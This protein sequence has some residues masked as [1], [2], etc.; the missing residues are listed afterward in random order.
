MADFCRWV[1]AAAPALGWKD[2]YFTALYTTHREQARRDMVSMDELAQFIIEECTPY[3]G[4]P[5]DLLKQIVAEFPA[6]V[7]AWV[8]KSASMLSTELER[9]VPMLRSLGI[10]VR[11]TRTAKERNIVIEKLEDDVSP[12]SPEDESDAVDDPNDDTEVEIDD[13]WPSFDDE[14]QDAPD[15]VD[16]VDDVDIEDLL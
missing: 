5:S 1:E 12:A 14:Q 2:G 13:D 3:T 11:R 15:D 4:T 7:P 6:H 10:E 16:D 9:M 8:P